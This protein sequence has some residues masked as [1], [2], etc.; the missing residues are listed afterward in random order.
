MKYQ[1]QFHLHVMYFVG[2]VLSNTK[3]LLVLSHTQLK[4]KDCN[5]ALVPLPINY[6]AEMLKLSYPYHHEKRLKYLN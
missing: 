6:C 1:L 2:F 3:L 4:F 5:N